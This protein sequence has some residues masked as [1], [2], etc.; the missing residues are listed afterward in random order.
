MLDL[1]IT[2]LWQIIAFIILL[3]ILNR[4]LYKPFQKVLKEREEK[5][6]GAMKLAANAEKEIADGIAAY[7]K[8]LKE[9]A[10]KGQEERNRLR[11]EAALQEK[12][13]LDAARARASSEL[14]SMKAEIEKSKTSALAKLKEESKTISTVIAEKM[15]D[16]RLVAALLF[17]ILPL[18]P[19]V[20][21]ASSGGGEGGH[22]GG[23]NDMLWKVINFAILVAGIVIVW[24]KVIRKMLDNR[25]QDI[26][27]ALEAAKKAK[28]SADKLAAEYGEKLALLEESVADVQRKLAIEGEAEKKRMIAESEKAA[29]KLIAQARGAAEQEVKKAKYEIKKEAAELAARMAEEILKKELTGADQ[30]RLVKTYIEKLRLH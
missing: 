13:M 14:A 3:P 12:E 22:E 17:F 8:R 24:F 19:V 20:A 1:D 10:V 26:I 6:E 21:L 2:I 28:E 27:K 25:T 16:R 30:E 15:L 11:A 18:I 29:E 5:T 23:G 9:A 7:E 4:L